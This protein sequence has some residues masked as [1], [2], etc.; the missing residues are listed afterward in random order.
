MFILALFI[1]WEKVRYTW[2]FGFLSLGLT[3]WT[4]ILGYEV[5]GAKAWISIGPFSFQPIEVTKVLLTLFLVNFLYQNRLEISKKSGIELV[6]VLAPALLLF[7]II[8]G[9]LVLQ[10]DLGP[11]LIL[12]M[13]LCTLMFYIVKRVSLLI[14]AIGLALGGGAAAALLF[15]HF[16]MRILPGCGRTSYDSGFK[17]KRN[18]CLEPEESLALV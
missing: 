18:V 5:Q 14:L 10:R 9:L 11:G 2:F 4:L 12:F 3:L 15:P 16:K 8:F 17:F 6:K 1:D 13:V 7:F